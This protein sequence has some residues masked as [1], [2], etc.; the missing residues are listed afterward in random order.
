MTVLLT[1]LV[2]EECPRSHGE[3]GSQASRGLILSFFKG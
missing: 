3:V 2:S 1:Y